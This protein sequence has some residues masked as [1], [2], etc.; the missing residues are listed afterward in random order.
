MSKITY[1]EDIIDE[2]H[3]NYDV[4]RRQLEEI[5]KLNIKYIHQLVNKPEVISILLPNLGV[6]HFN[7]GRARYSYKNSNTYKRYRDLISSQIDLVDKLGKQH[8]DLVHKRRSYYTRI[9]RYFF[10]NREDRKKS[11]K[12][13]VF[14]KIESLQNSKI[15]E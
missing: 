5:C 7:A 15:D 2:L 9:R 6:L 8:K 1:L 13:Q 3:K 14:K 4:D 12:F 10:K 11:S